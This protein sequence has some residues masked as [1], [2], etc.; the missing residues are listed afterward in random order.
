MAQ[1][2]KYK[3]GKRIKGVST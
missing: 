3:A 2:L 1:I